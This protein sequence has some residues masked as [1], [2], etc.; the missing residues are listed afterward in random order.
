MFRKM[1][2]VELVFVKL[3][4]ATLRKSLNQRT[5]EKLI[6]DFAKCRILKFYLKMVNTREN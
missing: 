6:E 2:T 5:F 4:T 1:D 3:K